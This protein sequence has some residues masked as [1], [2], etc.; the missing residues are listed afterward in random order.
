MENKAGPEEVE[1]EYE[2]PDDIRYGPGPTRPTASSRP[3]MPLPE[4]P[5]SPVEEPEDIYQNDGEVEY[6]DM[7]L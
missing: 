1:D 2:A 4:R 6:V 7:K 3:S 5:D